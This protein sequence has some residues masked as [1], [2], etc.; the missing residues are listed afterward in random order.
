MSPSEQITINHQIEQWYNTIKS[1]PG[2][3]DADAEELKT[4][5]LDMMD[6]LQ[7]AG[8]DEEEAFIIATR[9]LGNADDIES[10]YRQE[11]QDVIQTRRSAI[12]LSGVLIY[13]FSFHFVGSLA[14][15]IFMGLLEIELPG[16]RV[17]FWMNRFF[18]TAHFLLIVLFTSI[19]LSE[20]RVVNFIENLKIRPR[21]TI[22]F[23]ITTF[24]LGVTNVSLMALAK[25]MVREDYGL[26]GQLIHSHIYNE[27]TFPLLFC[28]GF[29]LIYSKYYR[30][31]K[32]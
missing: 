9:R 7:D 27:Y 24:I 6:E 13:F 15:L 23:L 1:Q 29:I 19:L 16:P 5:L 12:I 3:T 8:L 25:G 30:K 11:N 4:H 17:I 20:K 22:V 14:K 28:I 10:E 32:I 26:R 2:F 21:H 18:I 31:A